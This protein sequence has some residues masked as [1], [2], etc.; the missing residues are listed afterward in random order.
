MEF[1]VC[2]KTAYLLTVG[3]PLYFKFWSEGTKFANNF[4]SDVAW[5]EQL[6]RMSHSC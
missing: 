6:W 4:K 1:N 5:L 2:C 3:V